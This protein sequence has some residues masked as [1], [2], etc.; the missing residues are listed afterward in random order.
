MLVDLHGGNR[1][2]AKQQAAEDAATGSSEQ[3]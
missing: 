3:V 2:V 1:R